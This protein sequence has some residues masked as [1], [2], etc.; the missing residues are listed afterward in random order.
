MLQM[1][2]FDWQEERLESGVGRWLF[3]AI[4]VRLQ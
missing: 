4:S 3:K 1:V 2:F